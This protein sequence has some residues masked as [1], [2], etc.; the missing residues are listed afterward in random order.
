LPYLG[1]HFNYFKYDFKEL[2]SV[3]DLLFNRAFYPEAMNYYSQASKLKPDDG[4]VQSCVVICLSREGGKEQALSTLDAY[5][6]KNKT[7]PSVIADGITLLLD[8]GEKEKAIVWLARLKKISPS[9]TKGKQ[10]TAMLAEKDGNLNEALENYNAAFNADPSDLT[11][12]RLLGNLLIRQKLWG[13]AIIHFKKA[14]E[15][16]PNEPYILERLG[17]LLVTCTDSSLRDVG[18]GKD[19]C[20]RAF[21]N[22]SSHSVTLISAGR[23]LAIAYALLGDKQNA[24]KVIRMTINSANE[25]DVPASYHEDLRNLLQKFNSLN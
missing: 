17:T 19:L 23:S 18:Q 24:I 8:L 14:L 12:V 16:H 25:Q 15:V 5:L 1:Q 11:T 13:K 10:L 3:G 21:I 4:Q 6:E 7:N 20:E 2:K 22:I 9:L